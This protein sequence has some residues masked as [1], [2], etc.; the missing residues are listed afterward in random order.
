MTAK[1]WLNRARR[2]DE[3]INI[4]Q[5]EKQ[6][7]LYR[8]TSGTARYNATRAQTSRRNASED[9]FIAYAEYDAL[10]DG[11]VDELYETKKEIL[12]V[13]NEVEDDTLRLLLLLRYVRFEKWETIVEKL[14]YSYAHIIQRLHPRALR[15][16]E[17]VMREKMIQNDNIK[18]GK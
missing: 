16:A 9:R 5:S 12:G 13:I 15:A 8:A 4:L 17:A 7:A 11:R 3:E 18:F 1:E 10:I 14:H 2:L 6:A